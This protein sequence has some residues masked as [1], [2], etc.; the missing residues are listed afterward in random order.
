MAEHDVRQ[1]QH[2]QNPRG[3]AARSAGARD[4]SDGRAQDAGACAAAAQSAHG[5]Q[6]TLTFSHKVI[7]LVLSV[8]LILLMVPSAFAEPADGGA[9]GGATAGST[10]GAGAEGSSSGA[11]NKAYN[12]EKVIRI[13][14]YFGD[15]AFQDGFSDDVR[16][17]GYAYAYYQELAPYAAWDY[18]YSY[19]S[20]EDALDALRRGEVDVVAGISKTPELEDELLFSA[21]DMGL[22]GEPVYFVMNKNRADLMNE[23]NAANEE[24]LANNPKFQTQ[25]WQEYYE[26][27]K[28]VTELDADERAWLAK[29]GSLKLGYLAK[30]L[31]I[32]GRDDEGNAI[33]AI[34]AV[35]SIMED[36]LE[37]PI[38]TVPF[39]SHVTMT[40]ALLNNEIDVMFPVY[41]DPWTNENSGLYQTEPLVEDRILVAYVGDY[42]DQ[43]LDRVA[44]SEASIGQQMFLAQYG[45]DSEVVVYPDRPAAFEAVLNGEANCTLGSANVMQLFIAEH[46]EYD[47]FNT[48]YLDS[49]EGFSFAVKRSDSTLAVIMQ[50]TVQQ[51]DDTVIMNEMIRYSHAQTPFSLLDVIQHYA[52]PLLVI[53]ILIIAVIVIVFIRYR[54]RVNA[55]NKEQAATRSAL[56]TALTAADN[57]SAAKTSFLSNMSH[58]IRTPLNAIIGMT[59]IAG[60]NVTDTNRV[61]DC[62]TKI[63]SSSRHL[64]ALINEI[65][66]V[67]KI[68]SG[69]IE[70]SEEPFDLS[71]MLKDLIDIN[72][73]QADAKG[74]KVIIR[75]KDVVH[76]EVIGDHVRLQQIYTNLVSNAIKYTQPGGTI[77]ITLAEKSTGSPTLAQYEFT[78]R[79][80]GIGMSEEYLPHLFEA[81][82]RADD[83]DA[84]NQ[85]GT[86]LGMPIALSTARM[87][88]GDIKVES[89]LGK[90]S[91]FTATVFLKIAELDADLYEEFAGLRV[92]IVDDDETICESTSIMLT[93]LGMNCDYVLSG[94]E[95]VNKLVAGEQAGETYFV[96]II[97]WVMPNMDGVETIRE[98]RKH[99][100][101]E[102]PI[103]VISAYDWS[104]I[105]AD[106]RE[107]GASFFVSKPL[108]KSRL[109]HLFAQIIGQE[110][111][112]TPEDLNVLT[113][114]ID[115]TGKRALLAEDNDLNAEVACTFLGMTGLEIERVMNGE[116]A[117]HAIEEHE[118]GYYD[119]VFMD[120]QMPI[121]NGLEATRAIRALEREDTDLDELPIF[122]MTAN[123]FVDDVRKTKEAGMNGHFA[124]P[125]DFNVVIQTVYQYLS[126][127]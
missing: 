73:P 103:I 31:P 62:L 41:S 55:F 86:G 123:A 75:V 76:E 60:A 96:A 120:M 107:A 27:D 58:D 15:P 26:D 23:L 110:A 11:E 32:S 101:Q 13:G 54:R 111:E 78:V 36:Y 81:F 97:D 39:D 12:I 49:T 51:I 44:V 50:K 14:Y 87:M 104:E 2:A 22:E 59:A 106:A 93:D 20:R 6:R 95:A 102:V 118:P 48:V 43:L 94:R 8:A 24:L 1:G 40:D 82:T 17:S 5:A 61:K 30:N 114:E 56:E 116:E 113:E 88:N 34:G 38:E 121:M 84:S 19:L 53:G 92:L 105:E 72:K 91:T 126:K 99:V 57:A 83:K 37:I 16:K 28:V 66:D 52:L 79:D 47:N 112:E 42:N 85:Q 25:T 63:A 125:L 77:D 7:A 119:C 9:N 98:I 68:E 46:P 21:L 71:T 18:R 29:K 67:S 122:A 3:A 33:G 117:V 100:N 70:L 108:F 124:K 45:S 127:K 90:G 109:T 10:E 80:N 69:R 4:V 35:T 115:F 65:L 64:L 89:E 74:Q